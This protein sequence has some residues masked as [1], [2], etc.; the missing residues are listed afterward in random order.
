MKNFKTGFGII[1]T[2]AIASH[3]AK[4]INE[5][6]N[7]QLMAVCSSTAA[8][9]KEASKKFGV[10][11]YSN[12]DELVSRKDIDVVCIC[13][14]SSNHMEPII[15]AAM[16]GKHIITEKPLEVNLDRADKIISVCRDQGVKLGVIFQ[17]RFSASYLQLKEAVM[18]GILGKLVLG[19]AY[20]KWYREEAYYNN[21]SWKGTIKGDGGAALINQGI[22]TIDLLLD[23]M[24]DLD[25]VF[26]Q[27]R[28]LVHNIEGEDL[29][30]AILNFEN[31]ALGTIEASTSLY[32]G[33]RERL[34]IYGEKGSIILEGGQIIHWNLKGKEDQ[35][36]GQKT[37]ASSGASDPMS[38]DYILHKAQIKDMVDAIHEDREPLVNGEIARKSLECILKIYQSSNEKKLIYLK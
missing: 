14:E 24:P 4:S 15:A 3:H 9:A 13:T 38:V 31:G 28:T 1:G 20:I 8:R 25:S 21:S 16:A 19:N 33:Y 26:G 11:A 22:H 37:H 18:Q 7:C 10:T 23:I 5:L 27:V 35:F 6:D 36:S 29:G 12:I 17:N 30:V 2:G 34:E 32:P